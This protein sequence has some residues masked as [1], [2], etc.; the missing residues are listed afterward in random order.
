MLRARE[1]C[2]RRSLRCT[3]NPRRAGTFL[4]RLMPE[5][6]RV[7]KS[8]LFDGGAAYAST[9][10][11][12]EVFKSDASSGVEFLA[13]CYGRRTTKRSND[14]KTRM[15]AMQVGCPKRAGMNW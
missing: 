10:Q 13:V 14:T 15:T 7:N 6:A 4:R 1:G 11:C 9:E 2:R 8:C 3:E 12:L 5:P